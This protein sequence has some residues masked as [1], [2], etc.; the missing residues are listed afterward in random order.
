LLC[1]NEL[2]FLFCIP[3][4]DGNNK[5]YYNFIIG[6]KNKIKINRVLNY[7]FNLIKIDNILYLNQFIYDYTFIQNLFKIEDIQEE[8]IIT[9]IFRDDVFTAVEGFMERI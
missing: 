9:T 6:I 7:K 3:N 5:Y 4:L 2:D 8:G 1:E